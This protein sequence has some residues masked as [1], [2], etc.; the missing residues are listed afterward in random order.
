MEVKF[1]KPKNII[2]KQFIE[3]F[4]FFVE[5]K[6]SKIFSY[7]TFPNNYCILSFYRNAIGEFS[8]NRYVIKLPKRIR[9]GQALLQ[10]SYNLEIYGFQKVHTVPLKTAS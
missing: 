1:Y 4:Y 5:D 6:N 10:E 3:G 7:L 8:E 9:Y 2:L